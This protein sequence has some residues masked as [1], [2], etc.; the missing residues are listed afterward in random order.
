MT[1]RQLLEIPFSPGR[2]GSGP[3]TWGQ[4]AI[5]DAVRRLPPADAPRYNI[6]TAAP[7]D[8]GLPLPVL[9]TA[10]ERLLHLHDALHTR[11]LPG[12]SGEL[13][14][15]VDGAGTLGVH[16]WSAE[17][18]E[19]PAALGARLHAE[20]A[21]RAFDTAAGWPLR[22]GAV[23]ADGLVRHISL[24]LSHTAVDG[25]GM[26]RLVADLTALCVGAPAG[27]SAKPRTPARQPLEEAEFQ[28][29][30]RGLRRDAAARRQ[31][32]RKLRLGPP[33]LF[34]PATGRPARFPNAVLRSPALARA[35]ERVAARHRVSTGSVLLAATA[36]MTARLAGTTEA[37]LNVV[38][39]NRFLP[40][41]ADAVGVIAGDG[42]FRL[43]DATAEFGEV[44]RRTHAAAIGTYRHAYYDRAALDAETARLTAEGVPLAD[45][46][47]VFNDTRELLPAAAAGEDRTTLTW[48]AEFEPR[49][50]LT[51]ALDALQSADALSLALTADPSVLPRSAMERFLYGIEE[52]VLTEAGAA[53]AGAAEPSAG[54]ATAGSPAGSA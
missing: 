45:R 12:A 30:E 40:E 46:S 26:S 11:L 34:P 9:L 13:R 5:W 1:T 6:A 4:R 21:G 48:P 31:V 27:P 44:V 54:A 51:Y 22:I 43:P 33:R 24:V 41:L 23:A 36:A 2:T 38:V 29:S 28:A 18:R 7:L 35:V 14:Q 52:L 53:E 37:V 17:G 49:P 3:A 8:P 25:A 15:A 16:L 10:L 50:G 42:P 32:V 39:N 19:D 20:L 47:C